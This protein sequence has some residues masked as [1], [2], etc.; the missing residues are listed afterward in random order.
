MQTPLFYFKV[1][2]V[3]CDLE[4]RLCYGR[5]QFAYVV[6]TIILDDRWQKL[7]IS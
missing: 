5:V 6:A 2:S 4:F 3:P 1:L 7:E